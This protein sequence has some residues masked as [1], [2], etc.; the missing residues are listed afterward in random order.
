[1][2]PGDVEGK[3]PGCDCSE[4]FRNECFLQ[5]Q[6]RQHGFI[7]GGSSS[8]TALADVVQVPTAF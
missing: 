5:Q 7:C 2:Q 1:L 8:N 3:G 6:Y 4:Q